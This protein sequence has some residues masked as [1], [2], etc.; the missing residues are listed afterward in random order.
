MCMCQSFPLPRPH[1]SRSH[2][3]SHTDFCT[4][5]NPC[6]GSYTCSRA[7]VRIA[8]KATT[9]STAVE[10]RGSDPPKSYS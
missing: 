6:T 9:A 7:V 8:N 3:G 4:G 2:A 1:D 5:A 10:T